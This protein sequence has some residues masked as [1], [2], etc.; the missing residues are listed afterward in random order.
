M[1]LVK[2]TA[3]IR[4][5]ALESVETRLK[6]VGVPGITVSTVKG[7]GEYANFFSH[8]W[9]VSHAR[10]ELFVAADQADAIIAAIRETAGTGEAGDGIIAVLPVNRLIKIRSGE[11]ASGES[12]SPSTSPS[13]APAAR[14]AEPQP[15]AASFL[16]WLIVLLG[17]GAGAAVVFVASRHQMHFLA[18]VLGVVLVL[19][20]VLGGLAFAKRNRSEETRHE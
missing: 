18:A 11:E 1:A 4:R 15:P 2:I 12:R 16:S 9:M 14:T 13:D 6:Q 7:F 3:V 17:V 5:D 8:D 19:C 20:G 10:I